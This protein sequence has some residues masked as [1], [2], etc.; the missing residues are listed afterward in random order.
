MI[1]FETIFGFLTLVLHNMG[2]QV[3]S[4]RRKQ[5]G[6]LKCDRY[7]ILVMFGTAKTFYFSSN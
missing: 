3:M 4:A 7:E 5:S 2:S 6:A 1:V